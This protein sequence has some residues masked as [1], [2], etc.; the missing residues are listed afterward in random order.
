MRPEAVRL[1][2]SEG[3][4][5]GQIFHVSPA[6]VVVPSKTEQGVL[7]CS[8]NEIAR[9]SAYKRTMRMKVVIIRQPNR[10][11]AQHALGIL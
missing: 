1:P 4:A 5:T 6:R 11:L 3:C 2:R 10:K 8:D 7:S 9:R